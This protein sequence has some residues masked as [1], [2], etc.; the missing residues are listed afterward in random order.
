[1]RVAKT[2]TLEDMRGQKRRRMCVGGAPVGAD[3]VHAAVGADVG[4]LVPP[5]CDGA[6]VGESVGEQTNREDDSPAR[7]RACAGVAGECVCVR[8]H[9]H[10][11]ACARRRP[12]ARQA[13]PSASRNQAATEQTHGS[14]RWHLALVRR[15]V[16]SHLS[17]RG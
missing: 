11:S 7:A 3:V 17:G 8:A 1:M 5:M 14:H 2:S 4:G 10:E 9:V 15:A 16:A 12:T 6:G 13:H